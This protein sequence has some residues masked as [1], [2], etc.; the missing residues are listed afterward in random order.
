MRGNAGELVLIEAAEVTVVAHGTLDE[1]DVFADTVGGAP[2]PQPLV[3]NNQ[4]EVV[5]WIGE[6]DPHTLDLH[7]SAAGTARRAGTPGW[8]V[9]FPDYVE[10]V[11]AID[12]AQDFA[13]ETEIAEAVAAEAEI[14]GDADAA[15]GVSIAAEVQARIDADAILAGQVA[16]L[17]LRDLPAGGAAGAVLAKVTGAD[18][19]S[20]WT[21]TPTLAR[22]TVTNDNPAL[23]A[24]IAKGAAAQTADLEQWQSSAGSVLARVTS[25]GAITSTATITGGAVVSTGDVT[26]GASAKIGW[27]AA[28]FERSAVTGVVTFVEQNFSG[29]GLLVASGHA[30]TVALAVK[31]AASQTGDLQ[32]WQ[33]SAGSSLARITSAGTIVANGAA[34][35]TEGVNTTRLYVQGGTASFAQAEVR[36]GIASGIGT[37]VQGFASQTANLSEWRDSAGAGLTAIG[38]GGRLKFLDNTN[39]GYIE[40]ANGQAVAYVLPGFTARKIEFPSGITVKPSSTTNTPLVVD[41]ATMTAG[42]QAFTVGTSS[43]SEMLVV[44]REGK[45]VAAAGGAVPLKVQGVSGQTA[46]LQRWQDSA[47]AT[48]ASVRPDG[49]LSMLP[50][51]RFRGFSFGSIGVDT[52]AHGWFGYNLRGAASSVTTR[53]STGAASGIRTLGTSVEIHAAT[54]AAAGTTLTSVAT[55]GD[56]STLPNLVLR[57]IAGQTQNMVEWKNSAGVVLGSISNGGDFVGTNV[58]AYATRLKAGPSNT[59]V[60]TITGIA[61]SA[62]EIVSVFRGAASQTANLTAW[63]DSTGATMAYV[64]SVGQMVSDPVASGG[65]VT[66]GQAADNGTAVNLT[67]YYVSPAISITNS[68]LGAVQTTLGGN[69]GGTFRPRVSSHVGVV[70]Q[71]AASQTADLQQWQD[72]T[73]AV[74]GS[75][76]SAGQV[77]TPNIGNVSLTGSYLNFDVGGTQVITTTATKIG[78]IVRGVVAQSGDL[79][80]MQDSGGGILGKITSSGAGRFG[81]GAATSGTLSTGIN[82]DVSATASVVSVMSNIFTGQ[83]VDYYFNLGVNAF[84]SNSKSLSLQGSTS[85][86]STAILN[87]VGGAAVLINHQNNT[88]PGH[89]IVVRAIASQTATLMEWQSSAGSVLASISSAGVGTMQGLTLNGNLNVGG[90]NI[91]NVSTATTLNQNVNGVLTV[92]GQSAGTV[93]ARFLAA[94]GQTANIGEWRDSTGV[95]GFAVTAARLP[96]W[97]DAAMVQ[98]TV[99]AAGGASA[100]P[101]TPSKYLKAV[102]E[103]GAVGVVPWYAAA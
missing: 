93:H 58:T 26:A 42:A 90:G 32:Q 38:S 66:I 12:D 97:S 40:N 24:V 65:V 18:Y 49:I 99:G 79:L 20:A 7:V 81:T 102:D 57:A 19:D 85:A 11:R 33:S 15:L 31:G 96:K 75:V 80:Q 67:G 54:S 43:T 69:T 100:L 101:A 22:V 87:A 55:F 23:A 53:D 8:R 48:L 46:D 91:T 13:S 34:Y 9:N 68:N 59:Q 4:G 35:T 56:P 50:E 29:A 72:S 70:V 60:G 28:W 14:R 27:A 2:L 1:V 51:I 3:T 89:G 74:V 62:G 86:A 98:T 6:N 36:T 84:T 77:R 25:A 52:N 16:G 47:G 71:G 41:T 17:D 37:I 45:V 82:A 88:N 94:T 30:A 95:A 63:Q 64:N 61:N 73:A 103:T 21:T 78:L 44:D 83:Q 39:G 5:G 10:T 76:G 92:T